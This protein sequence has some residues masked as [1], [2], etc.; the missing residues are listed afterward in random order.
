VYVAEPGAGR[1]WR[2][3]P[4]GVEI[5]VAEGLAGPRDPAFD[6]AGRL[7]VAETGAGRVVRFVGAF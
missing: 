6:A 7:Y 1:V 4:G 2:L 3:K 5:V